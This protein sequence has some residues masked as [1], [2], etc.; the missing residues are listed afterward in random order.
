MRIFKTKLF[1]KDARAEGLSDAV[2]QNAIKEIT[3]GLVD[4]Y[5]GGNV[6][7]KRIAVGGKG[8]S[9]GIRTILAYKGPTES[10]F[11]IYVFA[12]NEIENI[13]S[14]QLKELK[15]LAKFLLGKNQNE[16]NKAL[17]LGELTELVDGGN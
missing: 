17:E 8:K 6:V 10:V 12:K 9:G 4:A 15:L 7:K 13:T 3:E 5:L 2:L 1:S 11:C 16:L 14:Q